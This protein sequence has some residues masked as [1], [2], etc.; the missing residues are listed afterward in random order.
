MMRV[1]EMNVAPSTAHH[2]QKFRHLLLFALRLFGKPVPTP[3]QVRGRLFLDH[4]RNKNRMIAFRDHTR[5]A[6][7]GGATKTSNRIMTVMS[8]RVTVS[9]L[10]TSK[11]RSPFCRLI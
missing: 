3:H 1:S 4:A 10:A 9:S 6:S 2:A 7:N 5:S 11:C 8:F